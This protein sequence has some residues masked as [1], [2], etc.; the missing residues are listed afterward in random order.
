MIFKK[1]NL[2]VANFSPD[3]L[4]DVGHMLEQAYSGNNGGNEENV[5]RSK[6]KQVKRANIH[7]KVHEAM[8][9]LALCHNVTPVHPDEEGGQMEY[10]ASSPDE[11]ALVKFT[12]RVGLKLWD[13]TLTSI[14]LQNPLGEEEKYEI[15]EVFPFSSERKRMGIIIK[16]S[17]NGEIRFFMKGAD[18]IMEKI[19]QE[20]DWLREECDNLARE[21]LRTLVFG[22]KILT[23]E[24][25][26]EFYETHKKAKESINDRDEKVNEAIETLEIGL[27]LV[28][29]TGVE[30]KL[31][32]NIRE[33]LEALRNGGIKVWM[34]TGDKRETATCIA[35]SSKLAAKNHS[36]YQMEFSDVNHGKQQLLEFAQRSQTVLVV[37]GNSLKLLLTDEMRFDFYKSSKH[38]PAVVCCR[39]SPTQKA[40]VVNMIRDYSGLQCAAIGD[41]GNDV[42]MIQAA[43][44][45][46]GIVGKEG[47]QAS[48]AADYSI[49]RFKD[50]VKLLLWHGRN[51]Y[52]NSAIMS[53][54]IIHRGCIMA[55][56]Q[57]IF[58]AI[59][60]M[61][62][63]VL[64]TGMLVLGY[65]IWYTAAPVFALCINR[66]ITSITATTYPE[67][68]IDLSKG[69][70]L[71][72]FTFCMVLLITV[73]QASAL[74]ISGIF[75]D[76][77][78]IDVTAVTFTALC[79]VELI[80]IAMIV[81]K[82]HPLIVISEIATIALLPLC[83][84]PFGSYY[85]MY[86]YFFF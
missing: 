13:R 36:F 43:N 3:S 81:T 34:L 52:F 20:S 71:S 64:Y 5:K 53:Q 15:L 68:Y 45:G 16:N 77:N 67:L 32:E 10:Q 70:A 1:L 49:L 83:M 24:E 80:N 6:L 78:Y 11:V 42:S 8:L 33:S 25:W 56:M 75:F 7:E 9:A 86:F 14:T 12:E 35:I 27:D 19:V 51:S 55:F 18:V 38:A 58:S 85:R 39:C 4:E 73:Y 22:Q 74:M 31:Q 82:W 65:S 59:F 48:L 41:G 44:I 60:Y 69:R 47:K 17:T 28:G 23:N 57:Y 63:V 76:L 29:L 40:E 26:Q 62:P 54:F 50:I 72:K 46:I 37:D 61:S 66:D 21:G 30:D 79:L 84:I 2:G